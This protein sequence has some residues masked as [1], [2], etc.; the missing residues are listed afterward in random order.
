MTNKDKNNSLKAWPWPTY[1]SINKSSDD[2]FTDVIEWTEAEEEAFLKI[3]D[4]CD[5]LGR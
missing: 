5:N 1:N 4:N 3:I 2:D